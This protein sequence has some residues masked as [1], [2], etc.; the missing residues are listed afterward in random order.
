MNGLIITPDETT[1]AEDAAY[2]H[3]RLERLLFTGIGDVLGFPNDGS[4]IMNYFWENLW[5]TNI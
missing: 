4:K 5:E 2:I 3:A 1:M